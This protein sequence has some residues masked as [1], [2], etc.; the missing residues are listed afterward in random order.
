MQTH[1]LFAS[2]KQAYVSKSDS[3]KKNNVFFFPRKTLEHIPTARVAS[4]EALFLNNICRSEYSAYFSSPL[5]HLF[6][7]IGPV[8]SDEN[9]P[10]N[11]GGSL[12][13]THVRLVQSGLLNG[14]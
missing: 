4:P 9:N 3:L 1:A 2:H 11:L 14:I 8:Y 7:D 6:K 13:R 5:I 10:D 12:R